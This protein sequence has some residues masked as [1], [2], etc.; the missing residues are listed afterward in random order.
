M[1][2][3][4]ITL[5]IIAITL[6]SKAFTQETKKDT[7]SKQTKTIT[8]RKKVSDNNQ[9]MTIVVDGDNVTIN[10]KPID[11]MNDSDIQVI[12]GNARNLALMIAP[13]AKGLKKMPPMKTPNGNII[14]NRNEWPISG[15]NKA[16]LGV[17]S[18]KDE[19]GAK[20][21]DV[22]KESAAAKAGLQKDDIISKVGDSKITNSE[23]LYAAIGKYNPDDKVKITYWRNGKENTTTATLLK[24]KE[25]M[26]F[27]F[28]NDGDFNFQEPK[29]L[30]DQQGLQNQKLLLDRAQRGF[31]YSMPRKPKLGLQIQ[32]VETGNG[33]KVLD[34]DE[35]TP[36]AKSGLK[37]DDI[38]IAVNGTEVKNVDDLRDKLK[39]IKDGDVVQIKYR[40]G[41]NTESTI[42]IKIPKKLKTADL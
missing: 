2:F 36:A 27:N 20:I 42:E 32:D 1:K 14:I 13:Q 11:A 35:D 39:D 18:E 28:N 9:K 26:V 6:C 7:A 3:K 34:I 16:V 24:S 8:I 30:L 25:M 15:G 38:I 22:A 10:G 12:K 17:T 4:F 23:D 40:R 41:N 37:K 29:I 5:A 33:V 21:N 31:S 19:K